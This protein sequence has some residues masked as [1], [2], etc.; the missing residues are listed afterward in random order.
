MDDRIILAVLS[1]LGIAVTFV[2]F[3]LLLAGH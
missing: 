2:S 1:A 3:G